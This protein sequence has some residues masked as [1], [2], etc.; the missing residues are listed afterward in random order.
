[1]VINE[2]KKLLLKIVYVV[3]LMTL[4]KKLKIMILRI[5]YWVKNHMN[6]IW[7]MDVSY[8]TLIGTKPLGIMCDKVV[9]FITDYDGTECLVLFGT[10]KYAIFNRIRFLIGL[11]KMHYICWLFYTKIKIDSDDDFALEKTLTM[12]VVILIKLVFN[13]H[14]SQYYYNTFLEKINKLK[15]NDKIFL[16]V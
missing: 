11:K 7:F 8:K 12:H 15:N 3:I 4:K 6:I 13:K 5:F 10:E 16:L 9:A 1:M 2:L 14:H